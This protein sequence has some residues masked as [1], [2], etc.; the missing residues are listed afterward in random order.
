MGDEQ[1]T[2]IIADP[3]YG[4]INAVWDKIT[5]GFIEP[6][7]DVTT[8]NAT[9]VLFCS[10]PYGFDLH[11][12][13]TQ[14][15]YLWRWGMIWEKSNGGFQVSQ[16]VPIPCHE[17]LFAYAGSS[18]QISDLIFNGW[19]AGEDGVPWRKTNMSRNGDT[20]ECY[21]RT[22]LHHSQ[23][24]P[25]GKRWIRSVLH[26][27]AKKNMRECER[28]IHPTQ[29]PLEIVSKL[30]ILLANEGDLIYDP[31][32]GSGTTLISCEHTK[33]RCFGMEIS[34][35]YCRAIIE[36]W[37]ATTGQQATRVP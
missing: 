29:K 27:R 6:L 37:Q 20:F 7:S 8:P 10:L 31:F 3:P 16:Y 14:A 2:A 19:L 30:A 11:R 25:S 18:C 21:S 1:A 13:M 4:Q 12:E 9:I 35:T 26:G 34:P 32:L 36:R 23:G 33:R 15:G 5:F 22:S 28:T 17:Y 24:H